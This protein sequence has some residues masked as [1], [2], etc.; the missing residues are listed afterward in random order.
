MDQNEL[1]KIINLH[2]LWLDHNPV[3]QRADLSEECLREMDFRG[4]DLAYATFIDADLTGANFAAANLS[5]ANFTNANLSDAICCHAQFIGTNLS[6]ANLSG[7][8]F[9]HARFFR[10]IIKKSK[11]ARGQIKK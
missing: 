1:N 11:N 9:T 6:D 3:G 7:A 10:I 2:R 4:A 5:E 8:D